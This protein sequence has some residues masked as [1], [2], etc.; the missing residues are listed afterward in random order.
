MVRQGRSI[1]VVKPLC[2]RK[3]TLIVAT[4]S[5]SPLAQEIAA[6]PSVLSKSITSSGR[7]TIVVGTG[8]TYN[9]CQEALTT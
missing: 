5:A 7:K 1:S 9:G 8:Y 6:L 2:A 3:V 4:L